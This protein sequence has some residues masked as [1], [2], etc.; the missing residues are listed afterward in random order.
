MIKIDGLTPLIQ[1]FDMPRNANA[2]RSLA[3]LKDNTGDLDSANSFG[4]W[5]LIYTG[6]TTSPTV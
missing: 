4:A 2:V 3:L 6:F 1:V 5:R